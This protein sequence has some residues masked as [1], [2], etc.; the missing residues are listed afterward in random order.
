MADFGCKAIDG[1]YRTCRAAKPRGREAIDR[2][3]DGVDGTGWLPM[4]RHDARRRS[5]WNHWIYCEAY[6]FRCTSEDY[7]RLPTSTAPCERLRWR[8]GWVG[9]SGWRRVPIGQPK[10]MGVP[11]IS[12]SA[13]PAARCSASFLLLPQAGVC[14]RPSTTAATKNSLLWSG[15]FSSSSS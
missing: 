14:L 4:S 13:F 1:C 15:P 6:R 8:G 3:R 12:A 7:Q 9:L 5:A 10:G 2:S 11:W